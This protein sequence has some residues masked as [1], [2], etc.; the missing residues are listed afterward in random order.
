MQFVK[1]LFIGFLISFLGALPLGTLNVT[2]ARLSV[3]EGIFTATCFSV[4]VLL[5]EMGYVWL[6]LLAMDWVQR[7]KRLFQTLEWLTLGIVLIMA[8]GSFYAAYRGAGNGRPVNATSF[9]PGPLFSFL[10]GVFLSAI[11]PLQIPFWF[12]WSTILLTKKV[13]QPRKDHY[14]FYILGIGLGT[15]AGNGIYIFG[16]RYF[17]DALFTYRSLVNWVIGGIFL[18]TALFQGTRIA[19]RWKANP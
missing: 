15:F 1:I 4:G 18:L 17:V 16:G 10:F 9:S 7:Q 8:I 19:K 11:N 5:V 3:S 12:G 6:S 14:Y 2:A 13:L